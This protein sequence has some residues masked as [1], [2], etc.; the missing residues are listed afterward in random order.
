M[1][2]FRLGIFLVVMLCLLSGYRSV[3]QGLLDKKVNIDARNK[4]LSE[5]L[6]TIG[7]QGN[8][9]FSYNS[10]LIKK[11]SLV[12]VTANGKT[13]RQLLTQ[14]LGTHCQYVETEKYII[15]QPAVK[16][17]WYSVSGYITDG[18]TGVALAD[19]S[20]FERNQLASAITGKDGYF[21][22]QLKDR[23]KYQVAE[24][25]VSKGFYVD[26][27]VALAKGFDQELALTI[28]P[29]VYA[30]P[31]IVVTQN[32]GM[33]KS[34]LSKL[35]I[36]SRLK[37]QSLNLG[38]FFVDKPYQFSL[39]PGLGTHGKMSGQVANKFSLN[40]LGGYSAGVEG[41]EF[42]G[43]FNIDKKDVQYV[44]MAG[45]FN[46]VLG[47]TEGVQAS[48]ISNFVAGK[49]TGV[50]MSGIANKAGKV[51]GVQA[52]G[53]ANA[54]FDSVEGVQLGG[55]VN[56]AKTVD[57]QAAGIVN[58]AFLVQGVQVA[59]IV[60][61]AK[62]VK[63]LQ[64]AGFVNMAK[65]VDGLQLTPFLNLAKTVKGVQV[66]VFLNVADTS[67]YPIGLINIIRSGERALG[68]SADEFGST[69][70]AFRSGGRVLYGILGAGVNYNQ[71]TK[72]KGL[73][74][75]L[76]AHIPI[77]RHFRVNMELSA[78]SLSDYEYK[79]YINNSL[80]VL[81]ELKIGRLGLFAGI[82]YSAAVYRELSPFNGILDGNLSEHRTAS[83]RLVTTKIGYKAGIQIYL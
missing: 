15:L 2:N 37:T 60:N 21:M 48:G 19:V 49:V 24:I 22:L 70:L 14:L 42:A 52:A 13:V 56:A 28:V 9:Y 5:V 75:G 81:P 68:F 66:S 34:W 11:D 33:E 6:N 79:I 43:L 8:F 62:R 51:R 83:G 77:V 80:N 59:G 76:G 18:T 55:I 31:G 29:E 12:S 40:V 1:T 45:L 50:Q 41:V 39:V 71:E 53:I 32:S 47:N 54:A 67:D 58:G 38:K 46:V 16:E 23:D 17:K 44:Q 27:T 36:S 69:M 64:V 26:T 61:V 63:G 57:L 78:L 82:G 30:I 20:V 4:S 72:L 74:A 7:K 3:G 73:E 65:H 10:N 25:T 35:L